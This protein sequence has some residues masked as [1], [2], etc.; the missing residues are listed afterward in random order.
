MPLPH[1]WTHRTQSY[2]RSF[3]RSVALNA[4]ATLNWM[5][6]FLDK[7]KF[8]SLGRAQC[9]C[10]DAIT[11]PDCDLNL[12]FQSL[13]RA[14]CLCHVPEHLSF[15]GMLRCFN[16]SVALNASATFPTFLLDFGRCG[17]NRSVALNASATKRHGISNAIVTVS[18]ARSRSMPLPLKTDSSGS[19][20]I[21][22]FQ[23]L[24]RA[25]CLCHKGNGKSNSDL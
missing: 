12:L 20:Q 4:S 13:G 24:G 17:F 7:K 9:L 8:Q 11:A 5:A 18:I 19:P 3:N 1:I 21:F 16:R 2:W 10:H 22:K 25:Q 23:S 14:Q 15:A 6:F